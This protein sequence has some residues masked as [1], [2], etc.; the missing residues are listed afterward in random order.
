[1]A[2]AGRARAQLKRTDQQIVRF[3]KEKP[4]LAAFSALA[5]GFVLGRVISRI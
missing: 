1:M 2:V 5:V 3:A 4:L